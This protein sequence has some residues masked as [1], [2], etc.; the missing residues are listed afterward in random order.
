[1]TSPYLDAGCNVS[2]NKAFFLSECNSS[3]MLDFDNLSVASFLLRT[4]VIRNTGNYHYF[5]E[6]SVTRGNNVLLLVI[7]YCR[8]IQT[9]ERGKQSNGKFSTI[10]KTSRRTFKPKRKFYVVGVQFSSTT[11]I[12]RANQSKFNYR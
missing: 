5:Q 6:I 10:F 7:A 2:R 12:Q 9:M 4:P 3:P 1:M 8:V 11:V